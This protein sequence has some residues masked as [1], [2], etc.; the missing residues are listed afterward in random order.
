MSREVKKIPELF[1]SCV[2]NERTMRKYVKEKYFQ[3]WKKCLS[4]GKPLTLEV[5]DGIAEGMKQWALENGATHPGREHIL[6]PCK[7]RCRAVS[8]YHHRL[9]GRHS[10]LHQLQPPARK[11]HR[12]YLLSP[13]YSGRA[14]DALHIRHCIPRIPRREAARLGSSR[15]PCPQDSRELQAA[16]LHH[17]PDLL[18]LQESRL[19]HRRAVYLSRVR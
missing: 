5:A 17:K 16:L 8:R 6:P 13:R 11:L 9:S 10:V 3:E 12:R 4:D 7:A 2:F 19:P 1:G 15:K 18:R 14:P